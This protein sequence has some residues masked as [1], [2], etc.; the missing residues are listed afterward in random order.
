DVE[1]K[2]QQ[3]CTLIN[4]KTAGNP[5]VVA[6][7]HLG[8]MIGIELDRPCGELVGQAL[9]KGLLINVTADNTVRLLPP[10]LIDGP[11]IV[12]LTNIL[13]ELIQEYTR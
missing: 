7:R 5:H 1:S 8:L 4:E 9:A 6:I 13:S 11:Q 12:M 2:G 10:L 3:I